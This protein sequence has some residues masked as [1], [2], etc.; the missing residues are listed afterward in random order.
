[1]VGE[2]LDPHLGDFPAGDVEV[3]AVEEGHVLTDHVGHGHEQVRRPHHHL[4]RLVRVAE[5]GD[6]GHA[7]QRVLAT[8]ERA[9]LAVGLERRHDLLGHLLEVGHLVEGD[10]IPDADQAHLAARHVVEEIGD[11]RRAGQQDG[12]GAEFLVGVA[13]AGPAWAKFHEVVVG[14]A[15]RQQPGQEAAASAGG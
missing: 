14:L 5:H 1:M 6:R 10:G 7:G 9:R 13:L 8:G 3:D 4:D 11:R 12:V 15:Q 2:E